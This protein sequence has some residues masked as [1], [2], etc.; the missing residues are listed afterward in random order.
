MAQKA[1]P[2]GLPAI[3]AGLSGLFRLFA[4]VGIF[5]LVGPAVGGAV[6]WVTM[7]ARSM[8]SPLPFVTGA[9]PE[10]IFLALAVGVVTGIATLWFGKPS[11]IVPVAVSIVVT[12][13]FVVFLAGDPGRPD[14]A[15]ILLRL[16]GVFLPPSLAAGL[17]CWWLARLLLVPR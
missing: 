11:W 1:P 10:G 12:M 9:Y 14:L 3:S 5:G 15:G 4:F 13:G 6:A 7:G 16:T 8:R 2:S 17:A